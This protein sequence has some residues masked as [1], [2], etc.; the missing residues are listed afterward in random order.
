MTMYRDCKKPDERPVS[1]P[2]K[3][4]RGRAKERIAQT[5]QLLK[6]R[7]NKADPSQAEGFAKGGKWINT[8]IRDVPVSDLPDPEDISG[9]S[10]FQKVSQS[11]MR[12]GLERLQQMKSII[13]SGEGA[14]SD[15]WAEFDRK[16]GLDYAHGYQR[17]YDAF[18]GDDAIRVNKDGDE[19]DVING[20]HRIWLAKRMGIRKLPTRVIERRHLS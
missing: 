8:G 13:D 20:R 15:Y 6:Q 10:D 9:P 14:S 19:Y 12:V 2:S 5:T 16:R 4:V 11:K 7:G 17:I 18:Y 3:E 1:G